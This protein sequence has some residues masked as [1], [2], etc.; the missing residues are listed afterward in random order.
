[1][2]IEVVTL[3]PEMISGA[4]RHGIVGRAVE[5]GLLTVG[6]E[7]PRAHTSDVHRTVDDRPYGGGPGMVLKPQP[8]LAAIRAAQARLPE[9]S[10]RVCLSAQGAPLSQAVARE[11]AGLPGLL[12][13][14]GRYEGLDERVIELGID[15]ELSVGDYVLSGGELPALTVIDAVTRLLPGALGDER[16]SGEDSFSEGLLDWPHYTR[17]EVFEGRAVPAVLLSGNHAG[18]G[19]WRLQQAV[20]RT[21]LRRPDLIARQGLTPEA[22]RLLSEFLAAGAAGDERLRMRK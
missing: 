8:M 10:P 16:S 20:A 2:K 18:I 17:P 7:D 21:W 5:R 13:V 14:A 11:L 12:L 9:G 15:R 22:Q 6:T 19:R 1:M 3:F 4:L